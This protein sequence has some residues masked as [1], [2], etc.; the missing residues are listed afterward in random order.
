MILKNDQ[1]CIGLIVSIFVFTL[2]N[3]ILVKLGAK[4]VYILFIILLV[5]FSSLRQIKIDVLKKFGLQLFYIFSLSLSLFISLVFLDIDILNAFVAYGLYS[6]PVAVWVLIYSS[7][8]CLR[9][10]NLFPYTIFLSAVIAYLGIVQFF[11]SPGLFGLIPLDSMAI[12]WAMRVEFSEYSSFFRSM[13]TLGSPQVFGL[14]CALS[15]LLAIRYKDNI[16]NKLFYFS[17]FGLFVGG[18]LSGNKLFFL[19]IVLYFVLHYSLYLLKSSRKLILVSMV[20][21]LAFSLSPMIVSKVPMLERIV[22]LD[23][24]VLQENEDSRISKY[25]YI[26]DNTNML[27]GNGIGTITNRSVDGLRA[28]ES[29]FLKIYY[30]AGVFPL[31]F[32]FL[33]LVL[34]F[35]NAAIIDERD[36]I[37]IFLIGLSMIIVHAFESPVFFLFWGYLLTHLVGESKRDNGL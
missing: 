1:V 2:V 10:E 22:S 19:L 7:S 21:L 15:F 12:A 27:Y 20:F 36:A 13:S 8:S 32:L 11:I 17:S 18:S 25:V 28:A 31:L 34:I 35:I 14:F 23:S 24:I 33:S 30:E 3:S 26:I 6:L 5:F 16:S 4:Y 9:F 29:Y 37:I